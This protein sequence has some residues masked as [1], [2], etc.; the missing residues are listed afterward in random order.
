MTRAA[1]EGVPTRGTRERL[2]A[3]PGVAAGFDALAGALDEL[4]AALAPLVEASLGLEACAA[5]AKVCRRYNSCST[6]TR[7]VPPFY[8]ASA[9]TTRAVHYVVSSAPVF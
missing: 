9:R 4:T 7:R 8:S 2:L 5:R 6:T 1:M 3:K